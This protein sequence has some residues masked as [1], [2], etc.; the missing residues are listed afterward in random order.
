[1]ARSNLGTGRPPEPRPL[2]VLIADDDPAFAEM[3]SIYL[4]GDIGIAVEGHAASIRDAV[5][6]ARSRKPDLVVLDVHLPDGD[7]RRGTLMLRRLSPPPSVLLVSASATDQEISS[8]LAAGAG[9][10]LEKG[11]CVP[12]IRSAIH[13][14]AA[15]RRT[16]EAAR[17]G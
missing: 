7:G 9:G 16:A 4:A 3:L 15:G 1:M 17:R 12:G 14:V 5:A 6:V 11:R 2:R 10:Y 8:A 13:A